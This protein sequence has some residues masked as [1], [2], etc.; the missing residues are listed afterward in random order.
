[1][2]NVLHS[3]LDRLKMKVRDPIWTVYD[4]ADMI[5]VRCLGLHSD[6]TQWENERH[7]YLEIFEHSI[8][9]V[10]SSGAILTRREKT[11]ADR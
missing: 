3:I 6:S 1:M 9:Y 8:N 5:I 4:L 7:R 2:R 10:V 11:Y